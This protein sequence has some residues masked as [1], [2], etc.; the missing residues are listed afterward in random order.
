MKS[1][2]KQVWMQELLTRW[3][4]TVAVFLVCEFLWHLAFHSAFHISHMVIRATVFCLVW[5]A[6]DQWRKKSG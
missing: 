1:S 3:A 2:P 5:F 4:V 6:V